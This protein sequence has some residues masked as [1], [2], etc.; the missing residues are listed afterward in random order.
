MD[1]IIKAV[2]NYDLTGVNVQYLT[3]AKSKIL[4]YDT[5]TTNDDIIE[6]IGPTNQTLL[7]FPTQAGSP[8]GHWISLI[9]R[10][11]TRTI[12][13]WDS[14][15]LSPQA[16][17]Q[18]STSRHVKADT[19]QFLYRKAESQGY[20]VIWNPYRFQ[21]MANGINVCGC[22]ASMRNRFH[23]LT[24]EQMKKLWLNQKESPDYLVTILTFM[25][26]N[27]EKAEENLVL[28]MMGK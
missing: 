17:L 25:S 20:K 4:L 27:E 18:Y 5:L 8:D 2:Y 13:H 9:Y 16:E 12:E 15:G 24:I 11:S 1:S 26:L 22:M 10:Q 28:S 7:L 21:V 19:L 3:R 23:Y 14:Y 6:R